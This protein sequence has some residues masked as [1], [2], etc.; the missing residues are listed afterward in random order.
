MRLFV[1]FQLENTS[2]TTRPIVITFDNPPLISSPVIDRILFHQNTD[3]RQHVE[4]LRCA[5]AC[6]R[7]PK[8][9]LGKARSRR[10]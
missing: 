5:R 2:T 8:A 1:D 3:C 4:R 9:S 10:Q 7:D 6:S